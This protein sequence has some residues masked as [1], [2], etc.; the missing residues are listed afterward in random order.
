MVKHLWQPAYHARVLSQFLTFISLINVTSL[1]IPVILSLSASWTNGIHPDVYS[2]TR[3][4]LT[5][6]VKR[7]SV[8]FQFRCSIRLRSKLT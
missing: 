7:L 3:A 5:S 2:A 4:I 6:K 8:W 1:L